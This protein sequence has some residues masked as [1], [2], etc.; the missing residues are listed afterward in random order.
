MRL[1]VGFISLIFSLKGISQE[2][3]LSESEIQDLKSKIQTESNPNKDSKELNSE[4]KTFDKSQ[5]D[6]PMEENKKEFLL[7]LHIFWGQMM[8]W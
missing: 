8:N 6:V 3:Q 1:I 2:H 7:P 4:N 5:S